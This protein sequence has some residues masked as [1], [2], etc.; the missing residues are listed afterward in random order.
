M[1]AESDEGLTQISQRSCGYLIPGSA[2][3]RVGWSPRQPELMGVSLSLAGGW[4]W[5]SFKFLSVQ[6]VL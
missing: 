6:G 3:G 1:T 2:Q 5:M 4:K